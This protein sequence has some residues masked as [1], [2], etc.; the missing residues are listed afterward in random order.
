MF[1]STF[2]DRYIV[3]TPK[4]ELLSTLLAI[5]Q[6]SSESPREYLGRWEILVSDYQSEN[7]HSVVDLILVQ[8]FTAGISNHSLKQLMID[9]LNSNTTVEKCIKVF[10]LLISHHVG[11][12]DPYGQTPVAVMPTVTHGSTADNQLE[13]KFN[14][15]V[16][17]MSNM[18]SKMDTFISQV[19][20]NSPTTNTTVNQRPII[21]SKC[22]NCASKDHISDDCKAPC[23]YC[24]STSHRRWECQDPKA[25]AARDSHR[26]KATASPP[27]QV[28]S[29]SDS[30]L[31]DVLAATK[32][33]HSVAP[34]TSEKRQNKGTTSRT[35]EHIVITDHHQSQ[36]RSHVPVSSQIRTDNP[37]DIID[38]VNKPVFQ[39]SLA[40]LAATS[41]TIRS[42]IKESL[43][44]R[45][46]KKN[47]VSLT[48]SITLPEGN[49]APWTLGKINGKEAPLVLDGGSSVDIVSLELIKSLGISRLHSSGTVINVANGT[50][51]YPVGEVDSLEITMSNQTLSLE[52]TLVFENLQYDCLI[53]RKS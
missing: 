13:S 15:I 8:S 17:G 32:R 53:G 37:I 39:V 2:S 4:V 3:K 6:Y 43:T 51:A 30:M 7:E 9:K 1:K 31:I 28:E 26:A 21:P 33:S 44:K 19:N 40:Q 18:C 46:S 48:Q 38:I 50:S 29:K 10:S 24:G 16:Q 34:Q 45:Y 23:H 22:Y 47:D 36:K 42:Q 49:C 12:S 5:K 11:F 25:V 35:T 20:N 27:T 41:S 14:S 52:N